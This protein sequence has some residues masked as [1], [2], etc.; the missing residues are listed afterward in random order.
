MT[1]KKGLSYSKENK[2]Q[3]K[4][5]AFSSAQ[6]ASLIDVSLGQQTDRRLQ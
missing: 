2:P 1:A 3:P 6:F 5:Y 4:S